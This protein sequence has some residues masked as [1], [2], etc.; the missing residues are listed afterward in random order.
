L[1]GK[2]NK[3]TTK[4]SN[5]KMTENDAKSFPRYCAEFENEGMIS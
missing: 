1:I 5:L 3:D 2:E 4:K